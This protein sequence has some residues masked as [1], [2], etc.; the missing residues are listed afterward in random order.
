MNTIY[1]RTAKAERE[2]TRLSTDFKRV[3]S[4]LDGRSGSD[5][6]AKRAAPSL[7]NKWGEIIGELEK[8]GYI[9]SGPEVHLEPKVRPMPK[10]GAAA[11]TNN[12]A[13]HKLRTAER[14][15][16]ALETAAATHKE[17][18]DSETELA[19]KAARTTEPQAA[20]AELKHPNREAAR[21]RAAMQVAAAAKSEAEAMAAAKK[22]K[23]EENARIRAELESA[24]HTAKTLTLIVE[25]SKT[26]LKS[27]N[28]LHENDTHRL[29][30]LETEN[31]ALKKL[32]VEAYMENAAL[33]TSSGK[34]P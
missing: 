27:I 15:V 20:P 28:K 13:L 33:K 10:S 1:L 3:L 26:E 17:K 30:D 16:A 21:V 22:K 18:S 31:E 8:R 11:A 7:R 4:L 14:V 12:L 2:E 34:K 32:L 29:H 24:I 9:V 6:L 19:K 23:E 25:Q 5:D